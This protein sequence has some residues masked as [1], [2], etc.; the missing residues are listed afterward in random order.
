MAAKPKTP[1]IPMA[2]Y[3][4]NMK[5]GSRQKFTVPASWKVTFGALFPSKDANNGRTALRFWEGSKDSGH[6]RA[7]IADVDSYRDE[8]LNIQVE[9]T[10][11]QD[12]VGRVEVPGGEKQVIMRA[13]V[14]EWIHPDRP[15]TAGKD[16]KIMGTG[17]GM[18]ALP[19]L[20]AQQENKTRKR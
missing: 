13:E 1:V 19:E 7:V 5:D 15:E 11:S 4:L 9:V 18:P 20:T 8:S 10:R 17:M 2:T 3:I 12:Q 16:F 6:Q 14:K